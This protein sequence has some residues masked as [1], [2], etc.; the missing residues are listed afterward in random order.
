[1]MGVVGRAGWASGRWP[2]FRHAWTSTTRTI[3]ETL[4]SRHHPGRTLGVVRPV[5]E[6]LRLRRDEAVETWTR[7]RDITATAG[8]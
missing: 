2:P 1:V 3:L 5:A 4:K 8:S 6:R 7:V